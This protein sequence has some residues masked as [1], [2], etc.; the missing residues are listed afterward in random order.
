MLLRIVVPCTRALYSAMVQPNLGVL[1][2]IIFE[3]PDALHGMFGSTESSHGESEIARRLHALGAAP[4]SA[5]LV[6]HH[7]A[8]LGSGARPRHRRAASFVPTVAVGATVLMVGGAMAVG[9]LRSDPGVEV[10]TV[11]TPARELIPAQSPVVDPFPGDICKGPPP[12]AGEVPEGTTETDRGVDRDRQAQAFEER[13]TA[14]CPEDDANGTGPADPFPGDICKGPPPFAGQF[15]DPPERAEPGQDDDRAAGRQDESDEFEAD[16]AASCPPEEAGP[17]ARVPEL[18]AQASPVARAAVS[19][20]A[21]PTPPAPPAPVTTPTTAPPPPPDPAPAPNPAPAPTPA[22]APAPPPAPA[23]PIPG[24]PAQ[25]PP[26]P[27]DPFPAN[28]CK[29]PPPFVNGVPDPAF[30]D[31]WKAANCPPDRLE[32][33]SNPGGSGQDG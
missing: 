19:G 3:G 17:P 33:P 31:D 22:P 5:S 25:A 30:D 6:D 26:A 12:F 23:E 32:G 15:P 13:K 24:P 21:P 27:P 20:V 4:V 8:L 29:G 11:T 16:K 10:D 14:E 7:V 2:R 28:P 9:A 18:P 1:A